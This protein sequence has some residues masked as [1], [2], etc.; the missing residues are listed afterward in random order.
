MK[1]PKCG[2]KITKNGFRK[3]IQLYRCKNDH[4]FN[5]NTLF[6][7]KNENI[8]NKYED[9][10]ARFKK[11]KNYFDENGMLILPPSVRKIV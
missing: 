5:E 4:A 9:E 7:R 3:G 8:T 11:R 10:Y 1:C 2:T 6:K